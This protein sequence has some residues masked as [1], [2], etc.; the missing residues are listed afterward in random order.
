MGPDEGTG[1]YAHS[2]LRDTNGFQLEC[3]SLGESCR[4][5]NALFLAQPQPATHS[6]RQWL[7]SSV[8][9][10]VDRSCETDL[11]HTLKLHHCQETLAYPWGIQVMTTQFKPKLRDRKQLL[12]QDS[13]SLSS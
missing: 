12:T 5:L 3:A 9:T 4:T 6:Q 2:V 8:R 11:K 10:A 7:P 1:V 13:P